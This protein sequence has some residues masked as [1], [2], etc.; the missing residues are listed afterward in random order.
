MSEPR[1]APAGGEP[2]VDSHCHLQILAE[3]EGG[4]G[5]ARA[6]EQAAAAG[7]EP[8]GLPGPQPGGQRPLPGD[9]RGPSGCLLHGR[10]APPRAGGARPRPARG[11]RRAA[12]A[13]ARGGRRR[14]GARPVLAAGVP[15]DPPGGAAGRP[16]SDAGIGALPTPCP[17]SSTT[18]TATPRCSPRWTRSP[19][20][21][22]SCTASP[23]TPPTPGAAASAA[24]CSP[25]RGSSPSPAARPSRRRPATVDGDGYLVETDTP[26]LAPGAPS[27]ARQH[28]RLRRRHR[29]RA[30]APARRRPRRSVAGAD[31]RQRAAALRPPA[32]GPS[33]VADRGPR[34]GPAGGRAGGRR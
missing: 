31:H 17:W 8:G 6:L 24:S 29:G 21:A 3:R 2:L 5:V 11:A 33:C 25:S 14:G 4:A 30:G 20:C 16:P 32:G 1:T 28:P 7:V 22:A 9:R 19:G 10:L 18:A 26:F 34:P 27:W 12:R 23:A 13:P 15:R